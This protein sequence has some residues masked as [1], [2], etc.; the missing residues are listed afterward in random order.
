MTKVFKLPRLNEKQRIAREAL[1]ILRVD[2]PKEA[3]PIEVLKNLQFLMMSSIELDIW[4][5]TKQIR[6]Y[7][8]QNKTELASSLLEKLKD[9]VLASD[10]E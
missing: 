10:W 2:I 4:K 8:S 1:K 5:T 3:N 9:L 7:L 6:K